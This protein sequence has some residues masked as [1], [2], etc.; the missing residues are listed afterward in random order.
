MELSTSE[1]EREDDPVRGYSFINLNKLLESSFNEYN[2]YIVEND[3]DLNRSDKNKLGLHFITKTIIK[4]CSLD[5]SK[6]WFYYKITDNIESKLVKRVFNALPTNIT[7][8][9]VSFQEFLDDRNY[10]SF[11]KV[12]VSVVSFRKFNRFLQKNGLVQL[13]NQLHT[14]LN[15][16][17][18]LLP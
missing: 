10:L 3:L 18:S 5:D 4:V 12:D 8:D 16:K 2:L 9:T 1:L 14:N 11:A 6:K 7:Y 15:I 17:L 13:G